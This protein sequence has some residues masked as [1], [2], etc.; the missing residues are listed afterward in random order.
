[1]GAEL[2]ALRDDTDDAI[3]ELLGIQRA[4]TNAIDRRALRQHLQQ[5][6]QLYL[7]IQNPAVTGTR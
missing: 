6:S 7:R 1:M 3:A 4:D 2:F 5:I